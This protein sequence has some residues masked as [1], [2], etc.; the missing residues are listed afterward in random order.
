MDLLSNAAKGPTVWAALARKMGPQAL[1]MNYV[2]PALRDGDSHKAGHGVSGD[3]M[4]DYVAERIA[5]ELA[6]GNVLRLPGPMVIGQ[7]T[8][9]S[10]SSAVSGHSGRGALI[11][12]CR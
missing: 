10:M 12:H 8:S 9:G 3:N 7:D 5:D 4:V 1:C 6:C 11:V 2:A